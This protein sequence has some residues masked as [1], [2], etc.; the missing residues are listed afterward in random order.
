MM[1]S[2]GARAPPAAASRPEKPSL[3]DACAEKWEQLPLWTETTAATLLAE[4][5]TSAK[6]KRKEDLYE[7]PDGATPHRP[8]LPVGLRHTDSTA[9]P[10]PAQL[11]R[12][13]APTAPSAPLFSCPGSPLYPSPPFAPP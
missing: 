1:R 10:T 2:Q 3:S 12:Q 4:I 13:Q 5:T 8:A 9:L 7:D 11:P 6:D